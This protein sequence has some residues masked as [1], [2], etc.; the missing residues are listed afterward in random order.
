MPFVL[1][2]HT[3]L[4]S[5]GLGDGEKEWE[6][7]QYLCATPCKQLHLGLCRKL[8]ATRCRQLHD[9]CRNYTYVFLDDYAKS[10]LGCSLRVQGK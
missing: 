4:S 7:W 3:F 1:T 9:I 8:Y 10:P 5:G 6:E 2:Y